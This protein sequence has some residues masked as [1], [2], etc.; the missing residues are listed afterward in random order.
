VVHPHSGGAACY[1]GGNAMR[2]STTSIPF[3]RLQLH[4]QSE[5]ADRKAEQRIAFT[6]TLLALFVISS[7]GWIFGLDPTGHVSQYGHRVWR[8][9]DGYFGGMPNAVAQ[10]TDGYIWVGTDAGLFKFDGVRF[11]PWIA[12]SGEQLP[13]S[14]I[15]ALLGARDGSLWIGMGSGLAHLVNNRLIL[16]QKN[17][18]WLTPK[19]LEDKDGRIWIARESSDDHTHPLCR[20]VDTEIQCYGSKDGV[21]LYD[22]DALI[23]DASGD[24]WAGGDTTFIRWRAGVSKVYRPPSL[25][26]SAGFGGVDAFAVTTDGTLWV[27]MTQSGPGGGLQ[28]LVGSALQPFLAPKLNGESLD[29]ATLWSDRQN[30][31]W[32]GTAQ[33]LYK[34]RGT[35]VDHYTSADGLSGNLVIDI[36]EDR[37]GSIWVATSHGL[38]MFWD[39]RVKSYSE[40]EGL[41]ADLVESVATSHNG[42]VWIGTNRLQLLTEHGV[43]AEPGKALQGDQVSSILEDR[44]GRLWVGMMNKL[45][46]YEQGR[47][48]EITKHNGS[49]LGMVMG[50]TEDTEHNIWVESSGP[51]GTLFRIQDLQVRQEFAEP[52]MPLARKIVADPQ[53]GIWLGLVQGDLARFRDGKID[54]FTFGDHPHARVIAITAGS[55]GSILGATDFG[56]IA[57]KNGKQQILT[58][59]NG[60]PCNGVTALIFDN[61]GNLWLYSHCGLIE[62]PKEQVQLWWE[63]P[64]SHLKMKVFDT[65]DG[66]QP[67]LGHFNTSARTPDGRLWFANGT[68]LQEI[69]PAHIPVNT[70][71]P[72]VDISALVADRKAYPLESLTRLPALTRDLEIDYAALSYVAPQKVLFRYILDGRDTAWQEPETRRQAFYSNLRPGHYRFHVIACNNDGVWNEAGAFLDF[73]IAP[74]YYQTTW[75]RAACGAAFLLLLWGIYQLRVRQLHYQFDIGVEARVNER[76]RI[77]RELHDTLLQS[78]QGLLLLLQSVSNL[79]PVRADDAKKRLDTAI[80]QASQAIAE[81]RDAVQGLR[82]STLATNDLALATNDLALAMRVLGEELV[83]GVANQK[84]PVIDVGVEGAPQELRPIVRDEVYRISAEAL[85]NAFRHAQANRIEIEIRY[86]AHEFRVRIRDDGKGIDAGTVNR[87]VGHFG[88]SGMRERAKFIGANLEIWSSRDS[89]TEIQLILPT[90]V[91]YETPVRQR[92]FWFFGK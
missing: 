20:V 87:G 24:L 38:D 89:G 18:E 23:Q 82:S 47:F 54:T 7:A 50:M 90:S 83:A 6:I 49:A 66:M 29:V 55:D 17:E 39:L 51:S 4:E 15:L 25:K 35:D 27:G 79:L 58:I 44:S 60:L 21:D 70:L 92:R 67:G 56:V 12:Q 73:S 71:A 59:R 84:S 26:S 69:D 22:A 64:E 10:T 34:I 42:T 19:I 74:A 37:E 14:T 75:F 46:V 57:W 88:L 65:L 53:S 62:I 32:V 40:R 5:R 33:G 2:R 8:V 85:R 1:P 36:F 11:I 86:D 3:A 28:H 41:N 80:D 77:A 30:G 48:R 52:E 16:Y 76:T 45:F 81:G 13:S 68:V 72:P 43:L 31:L 78:F 61:A 9:Q 91:S 63:H